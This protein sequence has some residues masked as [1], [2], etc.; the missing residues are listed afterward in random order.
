M[1]A[2]QQDALAGRALLP[3]VHSLRGQITRSIAD[4]LSGIDAAQRAGDVRRVINGHI[5]L[6][7]AARLAAER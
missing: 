4:S 7:R 6:A 1:Q 2:L 5:N 3:H